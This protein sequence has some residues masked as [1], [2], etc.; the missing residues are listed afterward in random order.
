MPDGEGPSLRLTY[1]QLASARGISKA[2]AERLVRNRKWPRVLGNDGIAVVL[3]PPGEASPGSSPGASPGSGGGNA[4]PG[5]RPGNPPPDLG[6]DHGE[7]PPPDIITAIREAVTPLREQLD[8]VN[9]RAEEDRQ[10]ADRAEQEV[11]DVRHQLGDALT[12]ERI[13]RDEAAGLRAEL[14]A[15]RTWGLRRRLR[16][17]LGRRR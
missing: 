16:W 11:R 1:A 5:R 17:A 15:R 3:V 7:A 14:D 2:S 6:E 9:R 8:I 4:R 10:R 12:A 13:A